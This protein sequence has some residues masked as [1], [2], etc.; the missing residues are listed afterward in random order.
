MQRIEISI[1]KE[2]H[3]SS[4]NIEI[5]PALGVEEILT[6]EKL[7]HQSDVEI[8]GD[9]IISPLIQTPEEREAELIAK[10]C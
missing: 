8:Y 7:A 1:K 2:N 6:L 10:E 3:I 9:Y 4:P 5:A